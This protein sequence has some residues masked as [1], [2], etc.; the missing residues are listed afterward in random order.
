[1]S[2]TPKRERSTSTIQEESPTSKRVRKPKNFDD[3]ETNAP[4]KKEPT[5]EKPKKNKT[6]PK[7]K[8]KTKKNKNSPKPLQEEIQVN[9]PVSEEI[10]VNS[11]NEAPKEEIISEVKEEVQ[12]QPNEGTE[13]IAQEQPQVSKTEI[14]PEKV[15]KE[16]S[17]KKKKVGRPKKKVEDYSPPQKVQTRNKK[18]KEKEKRPQRQRKPTS[19]FD[20]EGNTHLSKLPE[21]IQECYKLLTNLKSQKL[22]WPFLEPVDAIALNLPDYYQIIKNPM[23]LGTVT[24]HLLKG[25]YLSIDSFANDVR[26]VWSNCYLY[27]HKESDV[28]KMAESMEKFF[29]EKF[30][31]I[32][33][34]YVEEEQIQEDEKEEKIIPKVEQTVK[35]ETMI[36]TPVIQTFEVKKR[37]P[38]KKQVKAPQ[39]DS[40]VMTFDEKKNL[41]GNIA[42]L[43]S[44]QLASVVQIIQSRAPRASSHSNEQEIEVDLD[45]LDP[46][47]LRQIEKQVNTF[48]GKRKRAPQQKRE[49]KKRV[50]QEKSF[51]QPPQQQIVQ[52]TIPQNPKQEKDSGSSSS[53]TESS[54]DS[55]SD[56]PTSRNDSGPKA[57]TQGK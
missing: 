23:D 38:Q 13:N 43:D 46:V 30:K 47:T 20:E 37:A 19:K 33:Q 2:T 8:D 6:T 26:L 17:K 14:T 39:V 56:V 57:L 3:F 31:K 48:L 41:S 10:Q 40:R 24:E 7:K 9:P 25:R 21:G 18:D 50:T 51:V 36:N 34:N 1:M 16:K 15:K 29:E 54:S 35:N 53:E 11:T 42:L 55:D 44:E 52:Q 32:S 4:Q 27:N 49:P 12:V 28:V 45:Q 22:A 5:P